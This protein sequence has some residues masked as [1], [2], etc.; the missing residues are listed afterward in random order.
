MAWPDLPLQ[1]HQ[2]LKVLC[3][4]ARSKRPVKADEVARL[5]D[6]P[7]AQAAKV[8]EHL[9]WAGFVQSRRGIKGGYWLDTTPDRIRVGEVLDSFSPRGRARKAKSTGLTKALRKVT[10]PARKAFQHLS[11]AD[12]CDSSSTEPS[13]EEA[14][15]R[16]S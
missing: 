2:A 14:V 5:E 15:G 11:V 13:A 7:P 6:I 10:E 12:I 1:V 16:T 4:L 9:R 3:C 8:L